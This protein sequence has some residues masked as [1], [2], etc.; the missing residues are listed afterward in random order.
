[1]LLVLYRCTVCPK[2]HRAL[3]PAGPPLEGMRHGAK[4]EGVLK[5]IATEDRPG[6]QV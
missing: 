2:E 5:A 6:P 3:V 4:C 1:M